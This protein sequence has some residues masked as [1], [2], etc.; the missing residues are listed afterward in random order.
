[1][2]DAAQELARQTAETMHDRD[3]AANA[4]GIEIVEVKPGSA[5]CRMQVREDMLNGHGSCHGGMSFSLADTAF[6]YACNSYNQV[7]VA[8]GCDISFLAPAFE[9]DQLTAT[10][11]EQNRRGRSGIYDVTIRNQ[12]GEAIAL[13]RGRSHSLKNQNVIDPADSKPAAVKGQ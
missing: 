12:K 8:A 13:F 7:T 3:R 2:T 4:L 6:A 10:A 1:M 5:T 9:G 11:E